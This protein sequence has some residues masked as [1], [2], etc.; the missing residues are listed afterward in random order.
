ML[1]AF[2]GLI[3]RMALRSFYRRIEVVGRERI[4]DHGPVLFVVNHYNSIVDP[5]IIQA[6]IGRWVTFCAAE[7]LFRGPLKWFMLNLGMIP[8]Y[9]SSDRHDPQKNLASFERCFEVFEEG[10][11]VAI[12]P[13][14]VSHNNPHVLRLKS[15]A[16]RIFYGAEERHA[17]R[18]GLTL[19]PIGLVFEAKNRF[20]S[21]VTMVIGEPVD[22]APWL[23][24]A[25]ER[26]SRATRRL[27]AHL[28]SE[29]E[30][31]TFS[32]E[33]W[34]DYDFVERLTQFCLG[35]RV[36]L[37][38]PDQA[39]PTPAE[40][41]AVRQGIRARFLEIQSTDPAALRP[42]RRLFSGYLYL[43]RR[44]GITDRHVREDY[45]P[46]RVLRF[47]LRNFELV[48]LGWPVALY[49]IVNNGLGYLTVK[50]GAKAL[51]RFGAGKLFSV[52]EDSMATAKIYYGAVLVVV[53]SLVQTALVTWACIAAGWPAWLGVVYLVSL[54]FTGWYATGFLE[55]RR[56][57]LRSARAFTLL[58]GRRG[59]REALRA[60]RARIIQS[61]R[62]L[63]DTQGGLAPLPKPP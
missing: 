30:T 52:R 24:L 59:L 11:T 2:T 41:V 35:A 3:I 57:A 13:E 5:L 15:G 34:E 16:A 43:L 25:G 36:E 55:R 40:E 49:G 44:L 45:P 60:R 10:G 47:L 33:T 56:E 20:Q 22:P 14:G 61:L 28:Q 26:S 1:R 6:S 8:I 46:R 18:L 53:I 48:V 63:I 37:G 62:T 7:F 19:I 54:P 29:L 9:R 32:Q 38:H 27:T 21:M 51:L 58:T 31:Q 39:E 42:L 17:G 50:L 12:F 4:P 23:A